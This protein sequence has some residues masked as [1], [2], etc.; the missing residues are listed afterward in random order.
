MGKHRTTSQLL[1]E[2][3]SK[4]VALSLAGARHAQE[5]RVNAPFNQASEMPTVSS[6]RPVD[7]HAVDY[8]GEPGARE[9][10]RAV[11]DLNPDAIDKTAR[12]MAA[13]VSPT[14]VLVP[15]PGRGGM[16]SDTLVL[17][18]AIAEISG[19]KVVDALTGT[20]RCS[21]YEAKKTGYPL[22]VV[23]LGFKAADL[24][25]GKN[26]HLVD[27]VIGTGTTMLAAMQ[28]IPGAKPL[29]YAHDSTAPAVT[30]M[31]APRIEAA[32]PH[33]TDRQG[34]SSHEPYPFRQS[35]SLHG[36]D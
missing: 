16:A 18:L 20:A 24:P 25:E 19:A 10:V 4:R 36:L 1:A 30:A 34:H 28:Q 31:P 26:I 21:M 27:N 17:A 23:E 12:A 33:R 22:T 6:A 35:G 3:H 29:V 5:G 8:Y 2:A 14:D 7:P 32:L 15:I 11:K 13:R 9:I